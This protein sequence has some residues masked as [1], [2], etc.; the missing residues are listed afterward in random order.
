MFEGNQMDGQTEERRDKYT[1]GRIERW[2]KLL[3]LNFFLHSSKCWLLTYLLAL[4]QKEF[5]VICEWKNI[6]LC[7]QSPLPY[8]PAHF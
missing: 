7:I 2:T 8:L 6:C 4:I 1:N 3:D 5:R